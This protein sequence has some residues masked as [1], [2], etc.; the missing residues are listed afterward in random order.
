MPLYRLRVE[1]PDRPGALAD[2]ATAIAAHRGNVVAI[3]IHELDG[4]KA[5]DE[6]VIDGPEDWDGEALAGAL[7]GLGAELLSWGEDIDATD[8]MVR[9]LRF[10]G[11]LVASE[12]TQ[13]SLELG[14]AVLEVTRANAAWV[15]TPGEARHY[16]AGRRALGHQGAI[17]IRSNDL[18]SAVEDPAPTAWV[19]AVPDAADTPTMVA[20]AVRPLSL[21]FTRSEVARV[22][23][24]LALSSALSYRRA[25]VL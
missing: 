14:R 9:A 20:F 22:E 24:L 5:V 13:S 17:V 23:A 21:R 3:D 8:A 15:A 12:P 18:P 6:I 25:A 11:S 1:L 10:A 2:V 4:D 7:P 16:E 19:M